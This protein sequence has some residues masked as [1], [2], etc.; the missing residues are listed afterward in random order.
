MIDNKEAFPVIVHSYAQHWFEK[1][2]V[3]SATDIIHTAMKSY[4]ASLGVASRKIFRN[5]VI[6]HIGDKRSE[7]KNLGIGIDNVPRAYL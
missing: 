1:K 6:K 7:F 5:N 3:E 2:R 4:H